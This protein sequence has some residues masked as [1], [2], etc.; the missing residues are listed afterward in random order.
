MNKNNNNIVVGPRSPSHRLA[1]HC[2]RH[3]TITEQKK[4]FR[5][6][7]TAAIH[8]ICGS[9]GPCC[10]R[11]HGAPLSLLLN[12][13]ICQLVWEWQG[14]LL[15]DIWRAAACPPV[16]EALPLIFLYTTPFLVLCGAEDLVKALRTWGEPHLYCK[17]I[18]GND[19]HTFLGE[20][21]PLI[22]EWYVDKSPEQL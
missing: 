15:C 2:A 8:W 4:Q 11:A 7:A 6:E 5:M 14:S 16:W 10:H 18:N 20:L 12:L 21:L 9:Q 13:P 22:F 17:F 3:W 1:P 19:A